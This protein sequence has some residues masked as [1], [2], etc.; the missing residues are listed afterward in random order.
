MKMDRLVLANHPGDNA[1]RSP[2]RLLYVHIGLA[3]TYQVQSFPL[4]VTRDRST[5][6]IWKVMPVRAAGSA[7]GQAARASMMGHSRGLG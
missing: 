7:V 3:Q 1:F 6:I 4:Q 2:V 5:S